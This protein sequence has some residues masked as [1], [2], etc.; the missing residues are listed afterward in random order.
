MVDILA[1]DYPDTRMHGYPIIFVYVQISG[2]A[3]KKA[4]TR[5]I[6]LQNIS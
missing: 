5:F 1:F 4:I 3:L 2:T 6:K